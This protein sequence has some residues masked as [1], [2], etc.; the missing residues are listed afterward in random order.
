MT[1][2]EVSR[3]RKSYKG[4][5]EVVKGV[6]FSVNSGEIF[7]FLGPNGAGKTTTLKMIT[8]L[9]LP[10]SGTISINGRNI[11]AGSAVLK[12]LGSV[13]EGNRNLYWRMTSFENL[14]YFNVHKGTSLSEARTTAEELLV[15]FNLEE[16]R[17][18]QVR[19]LSRGMQQKLSIA[20]AMAHK[21]KLLL[22]D[23]PT[24]G[25]DVQ[26]TVE[27][28]SLME[29]LKDEGIAIVLTTHQ[30]D[31]AQR[32]SDRIAIIEKGE[33]IKESDKD[34]LIEEFAQNAY[35][36][37]LMEVMSKEKAALLRQ[38]CGAEVNEKSIKV[39]GG[40]SVLY[41]AL[42]LMQPD[43]IKQIERVELDLTQIFLRLTGDTV[44][45]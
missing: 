5:H 43:E 24:L 35:Q 36:I 34:A 33:I 44:D 42:A 9:I 20:I 7:A 28:I 15:K 39:V 26:A 14:V 11:K 31:V 12:E 18:V 6:S 23:E 41:E 17:S 4:D 37:D 40:S 8:G 27:V 25:L 16:K 2:V 22:L 21:P 30:L 45:V 10:D 29:Q 19:N 38:K 13:L 32:L 1:V 3:I